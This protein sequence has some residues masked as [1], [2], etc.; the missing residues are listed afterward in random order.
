MTKTSMYALT[1]ATIIKTAHL[2]PDSR[3]TLHLQGPAN[4]WVN[5]LFSSVIFNNGKVCC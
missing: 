3:I 5:T 1:R 2:H 4:K